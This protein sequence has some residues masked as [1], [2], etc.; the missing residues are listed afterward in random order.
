MG[1]ISGLDIA[2][3]KVSEFEEMSVEASQNE[4]QREKRMKKYIWKRIL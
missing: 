2:K 4:K 3:G 1:P